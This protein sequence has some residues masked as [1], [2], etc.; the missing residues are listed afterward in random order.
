[1][2]NILQLKGTF[3]QRSNDGKPG[4]RNLPNNSPAIN[5]KKLQSLLQDLMNLKD[6][7]Q[8]QSVIAGCLIDVHYID[9]I[10]KSNRISGYFHE[11]S[12]SVN[13]SVVGARFANEEKRKH[14]ITHYVSDRVLSDTVDNLKRCINLVNDEFGGSVTYE[15]INNLQDNEIDY[16]HYGISKTNFRNIVVDSHYVDSFSVPDNSANADKQSIITI[17]KTDTDFLNLMKHLDVSVQPDKVISETTLFLYPDQIALLKAKAPYLIAMSTEDLSKLSHDDISEEVK[18]HT[19]M[20]IDSPNGEPIVGVIDTLFDESV[21]FSRWVEY[22]KVISDEIPISAD[23]YVH[24]T[25]VTSLIVDG[26]S[27]NPHLQ[28]DCGRFRVRHFGVAAQGQY[29]AFSIMKAIKNIVSS[30]PDIKVWNLSLG[31]DQEINQNFIS[32]E[33]AILDQI[34]YEHDVIFV[35][36]GTN[37]RD[38]RRGTD[39]RIG[40][41]A[42]SINAIVVN[43]VNRAGRPASYSRKGLVLSFFN[44][45]DVSSYG[46]DKKEYIWIFKPNGLCASAG[47]TSFAAPWVTRKVA[48]LIEVLGFSREIAKALI[49]D[50]AAAWNGI[51]NE[52]ELAP[53][54]GH[55]IVPKSI[56]D[57][58]KSTDD[59]IKFLVSGISEKWDTYTYNLPVPTNNQKHPF[60]A[61][62]TLCYFPSCSVNQG[63]DYTNTELDLYLGRVYKDGIKSINKNFQ[64]MNDGEK[65]YVY[66]GNARRFYRK[67]DNTK[68][69]SESFTDRVVAR[70]A[71]GNGMWGVS[72]KTKERLKKRNGDKIKFGLVVTLK[73]IDGINRINDFIRQCE[74]RG[75][76]VNQID[77]DSTIE[78]YNKANENLVLDVTK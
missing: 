15:S 64:S 55:G 37:N 17:Y 7:W 28:D 41:P 16:D 12:E 61:K 24:G 11:G 32:P 22:K 54:V 73:E 48:F 9:V 45:P 33:A 20:T 35:I 67:W 44:K 43:S 23:D 47:G 14:I 36:A 29:S 72:I 27:L 42:D 38:A 68:H 53:L 49:V 6:F 25:S 30:N 1:M 78:I 56:D 5:S 52:S 60:I 65:H 62:A 74:L 75:W 63:V 19:T 8:N 26:P 50:A 76:L 71:Y 69:I 4:P 13:N 70:K 31:S 39:K 2:N 51:G 21:Y 40:S 59:E 77:V 10:A 57:I 18:N 58:V 66:E 34:Q 46:G 3:Q